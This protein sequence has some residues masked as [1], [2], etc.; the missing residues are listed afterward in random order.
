MDHFRKVEEMGIPVV[1]FV[2]RPADIPCFSVT[3]NV[4]KG[5]VDAVNFLVKNNMTRIA[6]LLGPQTLITTRERQNGYI[7]GLKA[8]NIPYDKS[9]IF[10]SDLSTNSTETAMAK[11]LN[12]REIPE[13]VIAFK[14]YVALDAMQYLKSLGKKAYRKI[15]FVGFGHLPMLRYI[16]NPPLAT[17]AEQCF[18][19]GRRAAEMLLKR[20]T[21]EKESY[22]PE[23]VELDCTLRVLKH[24]PELQPR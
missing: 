24:I 4:Y 22:P 19:I 17:L 12:L 7:D 14:D 10:S 20:I 16:D 5:T 11:M 6:H 2:R 13:A 8:N 21:E 3:S 15:E 18:E 1:Y 9:L 23:S